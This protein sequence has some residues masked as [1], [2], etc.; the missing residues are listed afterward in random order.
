MKTATESFIAREQAAEIT[1]YELFDFWRAD[2]SIH[3][4]YTSHDASITY[5]GNAY[6]PAAIN[7]SP[8]N[9]DANLDVVQMSITGIFEDQPAT[10]FI[11]SNPVETIWIEVLRVHS[12]DLT[13]ASVIFIGQVKAVNFVGN[14][15]TADCVGNNDPSDCCTGAGAGSCDTYNIG[16]AGLRQ[17]YGS[18]SNAAR[19]PRDQ[20]TITFFNTGTG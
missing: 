3:W 1:A 2:E 18:R 7:R 4:R 17:L 9:Y 13:E 6:A 10:Q 5:G 15:A 12:D 16:A 8:V 14:M 20:N 11:S 19:S